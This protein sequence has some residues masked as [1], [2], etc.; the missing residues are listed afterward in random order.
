VPFCIGALA[1]AI[2]LARNAKALAVLLAFATVVGTVL[3]YV[4]SIKFVEP[5]IARP[6]VSPAPASENED[7]AR[8]P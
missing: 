7:A 6:G 1:F 2:A 4:V 5:R 8:Q 3:S